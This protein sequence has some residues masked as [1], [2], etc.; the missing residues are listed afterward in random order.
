MHRNV[1]PATDRHRT[2]KLAGWRGTAQWCLGS[3]LYD[4]EPATRCRA[5]LSIRRCNSGVRTP[6]RDLNN[7]V[8]GQGGY[9]T[10]T[11]GGT[12]YR[13]NRPWRVH[14]S[15]PKLTVGRTIFEMRM[16]L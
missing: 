10:E 9:G 13:P 8:I 5:Q 15:G 3:N 16:G 12:V 2:A 6:G 1:S 4:D 14:W 11:A 7:Y